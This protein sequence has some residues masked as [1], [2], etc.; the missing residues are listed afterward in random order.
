MIGQ[1]IKK[2]FKA[3]TAQDI[4]SRFAETVYVVEADHYAV[5]ALRLDCRNNGIEWT[6]H[7]GTKVATLGYLDNRPILVEFAWH[8]L[9]GKLI[10]SYCGV[11][12]VVD[13]KLIR[14]WLEKNCNPKS[15]DGRSD[16]HCTALY[17]DNCLKGINEVADLTTMSWSAHR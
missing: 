4:D 12:E 11:S 14:D 6:S 13:H 5:V 8:E 16:A 3:P 10:V 7:D 17:F 9:N 15:Q 2:E 1:D